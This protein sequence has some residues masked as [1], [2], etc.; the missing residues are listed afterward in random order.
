LRRG[1]KGTILIVTSWILAI[2]TLFAIGI[3][4]RV[5]LEIKLTGYRLDALKARYAAKAVMKK[6]IIKNGKSTSRKVAGVD[7]LSE[8]WANDEEDF[9]DAKIKESDSLSKLYPGR[10]RQGR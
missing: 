3:A 8:D 5:G 1:E 2:V 6:A 4:F 10:Y 7:A 9:K